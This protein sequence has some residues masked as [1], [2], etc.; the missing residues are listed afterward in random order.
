M[1]RAVN[2]AY[3]G[4]IWLFL[5]YGNVQKFRGPESAWAHSQIRQT[6][7][8]FVTIQPLSPAFYRINGLPDRFGPLLDC[9]QVKTQKSNVM[10]TALLIKELYM[11]AFRDLGHYLIRNYFKVFTWF[12]FA[13]FGMVLY[14]FIF[15]VATGFAFD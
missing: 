13:M 6:A 8:S 3:T 4:F 9:Y 14:A 10:K 1:K 15:R 7:C 5:G 12:S 2:R 11:E